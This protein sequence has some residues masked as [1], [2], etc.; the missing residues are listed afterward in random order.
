MTIKLQLETLY[1]TLINETDELSTQKNR[2]LH[3]L[4]T[5]IE[6]EEI[7]AEVDDLPE[8]KVARILDSNK[9]NLESLIS[10]GLTNFQPRVDLIDEVII[11]KLTNEELSTLIQNKFNESPE[12]TPS[13]MSIYLNDYFYDLESFIPTYYSLK[14]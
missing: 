7:A 10:I 13:E 8:V 11:P 5:Q 4:L 2:I 6:A 12:I 3:S 9:K 1:Q 14:P